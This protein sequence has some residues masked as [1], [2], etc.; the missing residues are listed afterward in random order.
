MIG[1]K[2]IFV[3][4]FCFGLTQTCFGS[5]IYIPI[6]TVIK[7]S[8][9]IIEGKVVSIPPAYWADRMIYTSYIVQVY[10]IFNGELNA[11]YIEIPMEGGSVGNVMVDIPS[12]G[13]LALAGR[14][15]TAIFFLYIPNPEDSIANK[16]FRSSEDTLAKNFIVR[17]YYD[18]WGYGSATNIER[19]IY[20]HIETLTKT[21]RKIISRPEVEDA[22]TKNWLTANGKTNLFKSTGISLNIS[23]T[24]LGY[25]QNT[26]DLFIDTKSSVG[27]TDLNKIQFAIK[28][29]TTTFGTFV[30]KNK[31]VEFNNPNLDYNW[32]WESIPKMFLGDTFYTTHITDLDSTTILISIEA[33]RNSKQ[34]FEIGKQL[35]ALLRFKIQNF[36]SPTSISFVSE[37]ASGKFYD[38]ENN[39][40]SP[41]SYIFCNK[42]VD[43]SPHSFLA[44]V[45]SNFS[46]DTI[47]CGEN[48]VLT[49]TG[50]NFLSDKTRILIWCTKDG[51][52]FN[53]IIP[54]TK[55]LSL[56]DT[57]IILNIP[58]ELNVGGSACGSIFPTTSGFYVGK[59]GLNSDVNSPRKLYIK[60]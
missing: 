59:E 44:P 51:C 27:F 47:H 8:P 38:Y 4:F 20:K 39:K 21:K 42:G 58:C 23:H 3:W 1:L 14:G 13:T 56:T 46:P 34:I 7:H 33:V 12:C 57:A 55:F 53:A 5:R 18:C 60:H 36:N 25:G 24:E 54:S 37:L 9:I 26:F 30:V 6:N 17:P 45:V 50:K 41:L 28:Y 16:K 48:E 2:K 10:K 40:I 19:D 22:D 35:V 43:I 11:D 15:Q 49:I 32:K 31:N 52:G 29:N